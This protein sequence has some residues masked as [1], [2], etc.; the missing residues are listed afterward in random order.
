MSQGT[1]RCLRLFRFLVSQTVAR[2]EAQQQV[3]R[4]F[5]FL[6]RDSS[7]DAVI[8]STALEASAELELQLQSEGQMQEKGSS[9]PSPPEVDVCMLYVARMMRFLDTNPRSTAQAVK[10][11][12]DATVKQVTDILE[13]TKAT[14]EATETAKQ[15]LELLLLDVCRFAGESAAARASTST[16]DASTAT[17]AVA[18]VE[19][20][21]RCVKAT[22]EAESAA[23]R[24][25]PLEAAADEATAAVMQEE[26]HAKSAVKAQYRRCMSYFRF[27]D[28]L[29]HEMRGLSDAGANLNQQQQHQEE[30]A[31]RLLNFLVQERLAHHEEVESYGK[32]LR[33]KVS[34]LQRH[35]SSSTEQREESTCSSDDTDWMANVKRLLLSPFA[36][37][38]SSS[39]SSSDVHLTIVDMMSLHYACEMLRH[40]SLSRLS[41]SYA[42]QLHEDAVSKICVFLRC[43][44]DA[45]D[46]VITRLERELEDRFA[47]LKG[48][49]HIESRSK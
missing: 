30:D 46:D 17:D 12:H 42:R 28:H 38:S 3:L 31:V 7:H 6:T 21:S 43:M 5:A 25:S 15:Q 14:R 47:Q 8:A 44:M 39:I 22:L 16:A 11:A 4:L 23:A 19:E 24:D 35:V 13:S 27:K 36:D 34:R 1:E 32:R 2:K 49:L 26:R 48:F 40:N 45:S 9:R 18:A 29:R 20:E 10:E 41:L 37:S 33:R